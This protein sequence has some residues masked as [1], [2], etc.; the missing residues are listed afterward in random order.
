MC[1]K[2]QSITFLSISLWS[3]VLTLHYP[4]LPVCLLQVSQ[5]PTAGLRALVLQSQIMIYVCDQRS[6][7]Y[8]ISAAPLQVLT[9]KLPLMGDVRNGEFRTSL[10]GTKAAHS[11][12]SLS[13]TSHF[14]K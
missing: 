9:V 13:K 4:L 5:R 3:L 1:Q 12:Q 14:H 7:I 6:G 10:A 8:G 2:T 11:S